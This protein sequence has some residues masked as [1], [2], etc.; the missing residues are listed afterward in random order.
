MA[1]PFIGGLLE[2]KCVLLGAPGLS[3]GLVSLL[4]GWK[5]NLSKGGFVM[6]GGVSLD[7]VAVFEFGQKSHG[8][9]LAGVVPRWRA[10]TTS[11]RRRALRGATP[12]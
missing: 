7:R 10:E 9:F 3:L 1:Q 4:G 5:P 8:V 2:V 11:R 12:S 6:G